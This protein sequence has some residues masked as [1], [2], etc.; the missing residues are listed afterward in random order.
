M[1]AAAVLAV[2]L[3]SSLITAVPAAAAPVPVKYTQQ[4]IDWKPCFGKV[5]DGLPPGSDK[6]QCGSLTAPMDWNN[7]GSGKD[8][9][10]A[11][12]RLPGKNAKG[13]LFTNPGGPGGTGRLLPLQLLQRG[14]Q[15]LADNQDIIGIDVRGVGASSNVDC[16]AGSLLGAELDPRDRSEGN[17]D[18]LLDTARLRSR[19]CQVKSGELGRFVNTEQ[20]V[21]DLDLIRALL[22]AE[23]INYLGYSAGTWLGAHY[24]AYFPDRVG[25]FVLDSIVDFTGS[26]QGLFN[27]QAEAAEIRFREDF[28]S[29]IAQY[30]DVYNLGNTFEDVHRN[31]EKA[32]AKLGPAVDVAVSSALANKAE[33]PDAAKAL[34]DLVE[35]REPR[36]GG[37]DP[38]RGL[39]AMI[40]TA[41]SIM[42]NDAQWQGTEDTAIR[43]SE[44]WNR[45]FPLTGGSKVQQGCLTWK[46]P[47]LTLKKPTGKGIPPV[48]MVNSEHDASTPLRGAQQAHRNFA[49]SRL[50]TVLGEGDHTMYGNANPC[51]Q[52]IVEDYLVGGVVPDRDLTCDGTGLP[53][54][55]HEVPPGPFQD[56]DRLE[57]LAG[58]LPR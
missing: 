49:G 18:L 6:L 36:S 2:A 25:R 10:V 38:Q 29:W 13:V 5:P 39:G 8:I 34:K 55:H 15:P 44:E 27:S 50:L 4:K 52:K 22:G 30:N 47:P 54:P 26:W 21:R 41:F 1:R 48:L 33:F 19:Y 7:P 46:R 56:M 51:V 17:I 28:L 11:I 57:Q 9:T 53:D 37:E 45:K 23:K 58:D 14:A 40:G 24:T 12:T 16:G 31:Y 42:C 20:T 32:R 3:A 43:Q 35:G